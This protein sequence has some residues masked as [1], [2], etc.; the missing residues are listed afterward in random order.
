MTIS[1]RG[2]ALIIIAL[3]F[4]L[5]TVIPTLVSLFTDWLWFREVGYQT[6]FSKSLITKLGLFVGA[7]AVTYLFISLN[8]RLARSGPSPVPVLWCPSPEAPPVDV[9]GGLLKAATPITL[10]LTFFFAVGATGS[11][12]NLL[13]LI[14]RS[15]FGTT[16]PVFG[17]DIGWY[18][19]VLPISTVL[20]TLR[21]L[22]IL[23]LIGVIVIYALRGKIWLPPRR[24]TLIPPAD[25]H[26]AGLLVTFPFSRLSRYGWWNS[27]L[28][29]FHDWPACR[30]ELYRLAREISGPA[31]NRCGGSVGNC[32]R[33]LR[34]VAA[35][36]CFLH[37]RRGGDLCRCLVCRGRN[38][39][40]TR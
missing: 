24:M 16:D 28:P 13:Q 3:L 20:S 15:Q 14:H 37:S 33:A 25:R 5:V 21:S 2:K 12:M 11:W 35:Q 17:R 1:R 19:F 23:T 9:L 26:I 4:V 31:R 29:L 8:V 36:D 30:C 18:V 32:S 6:V 10:V 7:A 39:S 38:I 34:N 40:G 27:Q 22:V